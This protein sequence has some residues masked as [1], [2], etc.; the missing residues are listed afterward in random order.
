[1]KQSN[2]RKP[3]FPVFTVLTTCF[4]VRILQSSS[5]EYCAFRV[6]LTLK[7]DC[8]SKHQPVDFYSGDVTCEVR[9]EFL[10]II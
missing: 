5:R 10:C 2:I 9:T 7:G 4:D 3:P 6:V 8:F 1:M